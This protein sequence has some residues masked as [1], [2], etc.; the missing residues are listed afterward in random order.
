MIRHSRSHRI[1]HSWLS[2]CVH[3]LIHPMPNEPNETE[4]MSVCQSETHKCDYISDTTESEW[5]ENRG[6]PRNGKEVE[7]ESGI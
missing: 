4:W 7:E 1:S 6:K 2:M 3:I 5:I